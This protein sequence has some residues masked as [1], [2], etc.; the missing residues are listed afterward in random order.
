MEKTEL[1][2]LAGEGALEFALKEGF[3]EDHCISEEQSEAWQRGKDSLARG[4]VPLQNL[5]TG[6]EYGGDTVGCVLWD[7]DNLGAASTTGG[8]SLKTPGRVGD[9]PCFGGGI[10]A[11]RTSAVVCTGVGEAF[12]ETLTAKYVDERITGGA[13]P[14]QAVEEALQR[15]EELKGAQGGI[16]AVDF[17]GRTGAAFNAGRFPVVIVNDGKIKENFIPVNLRPGLKGNKT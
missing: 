2:L 7:G 3:P 4:Q 13:H 10:F 12:V 1:V 5:F 9:T 17:G 11:S 15:L 6:L 16:L 14:Q 8:V